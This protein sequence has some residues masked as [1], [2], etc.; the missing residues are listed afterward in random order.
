ME[1]R[2]MANQFN[3]LLVSVA[4]AIALLLAAAIAIIAIRMLAIGQSW[5]VVSEIPL[6]EASEGISQPATIEY[7]PYP[8]AGFPLLGAALLIVGLLTHKL[9]VA[10]GGLAIL[11]TFSVL[12]LF[13]SGAALLPIVGLLLILLVIIQRG[14]QRTAPL[15]PHP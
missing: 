7:T 11:I 15:K 12:F 13:S 10:W 8:A 6:S 5:T 2:C 14:G 9:A 1:D 3:C 4:A